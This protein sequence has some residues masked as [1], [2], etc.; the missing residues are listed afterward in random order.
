MRSFVRRGFTLIELTVAAAL[1]AIMGSAVVALVGRGLTAGQRADGRLHQLFRAEKAFQQ[2]A[3]DLRGALPVAE[4]PFLGEEGRMGFV[5]AESPQQLAQIGY[6]LEPGEAGRVLIR[7]RE[8]YPSSEEQAPDS[9]VVLDHLRLFSLAY[10]ALEEAGGQKQIA[11]Q[12][13]WTDS[14][15]SENVPEMVRV[16]VEIDDPKGGTV[17]LTREVRIPHGALAVP[18]REP[19]TTGGTG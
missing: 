13:V 1:V 17:S 15:E 10:P 7:D 2:M 12:P 8:S 14:D 4:E 11:W 18:P 5:R 16:T 9:K 6:R 3:E 19:R